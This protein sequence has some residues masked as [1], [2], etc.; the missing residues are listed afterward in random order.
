MGGRARRLLTTGVLTAG[1]VLGGASAASAAAAPTPAPA[2]PTATAP[3]LPV[4]GQPA[5]AP[6]LPGVPAPAPGDPAAPPAAGAAPVPGDDGGFFERQLEKICPTRDAPAPQGPTP[7]TVTESEA[8]GGERPD[9]NVQTGEDGRGLFAQYGRAG[10]F[11]TT[12]DQS[13]FSGAK[14]DATFASGINAVANTFDQMTSEALSYALDTENA[15]VFD[16]VLVN[17]VGSV[18]TALFNPWVVVS[19]AL[20]GIIVVIGTWTGSISAALSGALTTLGAFVAVTFLVLNPTIIPKASDSLTAEVTTAVAN[21]VANRVDPQF[22][23]P[24]S[25]GNTAGLT[26]TEAMPDTYYRATSYQGWVSGMFCGDARAERDFGPRFLDAQ[27]FTYTQWASIQNDPAAELRLVNEKKTDWLA[28]AAALQAQYPTAFSCWTGVTQERTSAAFKHV[29]VT[30]V[31]TAIMFPT[32]AAV[33]VMRLVARMVVLLVVAFGAV[34]MISRKVSGGMTGLAL[35]GV[36]GPPVV[37]AAAGIVLMGFQ[38]VLEDPDLAWWPATLAILFLGIAALVLIKPL[39]RMFGGGMSGVGAGSGR[40][41]RR[42]AKTGGGA[43]YNASH[44]AGALGGTIGG[45]LAGRVAGG[46]A[47]RNT[48][49]QGDTSR[50]DP[51]SAPS[52]TGDNAPVRPGSSDGARS[53]SLPQRQLDTYRERSQEAVRTRNAVNEAERVPSATDAASYSNGDSAQEYAPAEDRFE[54]Y[55]PAPPQPVTDLG[56]YRSARSSD[57]AASALDRYR[58]G[59][60]TGDSARQEEPV[61]YSE[62]DIYDPAGAKR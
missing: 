14:A 44:G 32:A 17:T 58:S 16:K 9:A 12:Y 8:F 50:S 37:A 40:K 42:Y 35:L 36:F 1:L 33:A 24:Q 59:G 7:K 29:T 26:P 30:G 3:A 31:S 18:A 39:L 62:G 6:T 27:A 25:P 28:S 46:S 57:P 34:V 52:S 2:A 38:A 53:D 51:Q 54:P 48:G 61:W 60:P 22:I 41:A 4:P 56:A 49:P 11:W 19:F 23:G 45:A 47:G 20:A 21:G 43:V 13:C 5:P 15:Q 55:D 10:L